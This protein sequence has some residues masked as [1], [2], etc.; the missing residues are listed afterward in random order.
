MRDIRRQ[1]P[2][3]G[4]RNSLKKFPDTD[5]YWVPF[6]QRNLLGFPK[7]AITGRSRERF[8]DVGALRRTQSFCEPPLP[9]VVEEKWLHLLGLSALSE[10]LPCPACCPVELLCGR[11][12]VDV[13]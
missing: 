13:L 3:L 10:L 6:D 11:K 7:A 2:Q 5:E 9:A 1:S 4:W 12:V 8:N